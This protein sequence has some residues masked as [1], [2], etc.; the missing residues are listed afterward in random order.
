MRIFMGGGM[1]AAFTAM[2][3][4]A[5]IARAAPG[6][7]PFNEVYPVASAL[8]AK[9]Q[10]G[11]LA[12]K[13]AAKSSA[14]LAACEAL[15]GAFGPLVSSVTGAETAF[16]STVADERALVATACPKP[17]VDHAACA[18]ARREA[19]GTIRSASLTRRAAL[20]T[21]RSAIESNRLTFWATIRALRA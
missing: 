19:R 17:V 13:L 16:S 10:A 3:A 11:T 2:L 21:F 15:S 9:A 1:A 20:L 14:V 6:E 18:A 12:P 7:R 4:G 5:S 8:C